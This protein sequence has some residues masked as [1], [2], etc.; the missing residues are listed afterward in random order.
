MNEIKVSTTLQLEK[1]AFKVPKIGNSIQNITQNGLGGGGPGH[2]VATNVAA[3]VTVTVGGVAAAN[4]GWAYFKNTEDAGGANLEIGR[5]DAATFRPVGKL[6]P[7]E[8]CVFRLMP[9]I[10]LAVRS[11]GA[12]TPANDV[13]TIVQVLAD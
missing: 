10:T 8:E 5:V 4:Y 1:G 11:D 13:D 7:G 6:K 2:V 9:G 12:A 3:G